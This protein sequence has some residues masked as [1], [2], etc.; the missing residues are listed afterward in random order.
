MVYQKK[1]ILT[2][3]K[4]WPKSAEI[5]VFIVFRALHLKSATPQ[6]MDLY[7]YICCGAII[8]AILAF[9]MVINWAKL[10]FKKTLIVKKTIKIGVSAFFEKKG[11][12]YFEWLLT[13]PSL[14]FYFGANL[15]QLVTITWPN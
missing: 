11:A 7:I 8:W 12:H 13:G 15:A 9:L 4:D 2:N 1:E 14:R 6:P 5:L 3:P 10:A